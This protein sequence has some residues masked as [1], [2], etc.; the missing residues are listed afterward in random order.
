[1]GK[2]LSSL[3]LTCKTETLLVPLL[4]KGM[5]KMESDKVWEVLGSGMEYPVGNVGCPP[6]NHLLFI[7]TIIMPAWT[8]DSP[9]A[10]FGEEHRGWI[11]LSPNPSSS[12]L[13][14]ACPEQGSSSL[15]ASSV[16]WGRSTL[17]HR[18]RNEMQSNGVPPAPAL[19]PPPP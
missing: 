6:N 18:P 19:P 15:R 16:K 9:S 1:M 5:G 12:F 11:H 14:I 7:V 10:T 8:W 13:P 17:P 2:P 4:Q 3:G